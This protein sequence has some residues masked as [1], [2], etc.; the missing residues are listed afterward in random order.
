MNRLS[1]LRRRYL[2]GRAPPGPLRALF[3]EPWPSTARDARDTPL[4]ALDLETTGLDAT[5]DAIVSAAW[6]PIDA[7]RIE[8]SRGSRRV[9]LP[10]EG[11]L[12]AESVCIHGIGH[13]RAAGG[14]ELEPLLLELFTAL[15][16]R[17][18]VA[19][20]APLDVSFLA[21]AC[22]RVFEASFAWP[23]IDTL[24]LLRTELAMEERPIANGELRLAAAR[25]RLGL[26]QYPSHDALWDAVS[27][28]ELWLALAAGWAG[29]GKLP[30]GR[31]CQVLPR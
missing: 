25:E 19:H 4:L 8:L 18:L 12:T 14:V 16:G 21:A 5:R 1:H 27:A 7:G 3:E 13:D 15:R 6:V 24:A 28:A 31:V 29:R 10:P 20:H 23:S 9:V 17:V 22:R 26:P 30:L 2:L 11:A